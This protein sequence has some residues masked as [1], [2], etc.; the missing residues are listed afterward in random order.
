MLS[1]LPKVAK[2][3]SLLGRNK[4]SFGTQMITIK[5]TQITQNN[6]GVS[7]RILI[8]FFLISDYKHWSG[9]SFKEET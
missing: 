5:A 6:W 7:F 8:M 2:E 1:D 9:N 3:N 4:E